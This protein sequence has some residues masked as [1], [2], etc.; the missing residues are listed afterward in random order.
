MTV[1]NVAAMATRGR[2]DAFQLGP[3]MVSPSD[4]SVL[5]RRSRPIWV[6][7]VALAWAAVPPMEATAM[8]D[9]ITLTQ[10][11]QGSTVDVTVGQSVAVD[12]PENASTGYR[13]AVDHIDPALAE[14]AEG[15]PRY[16]ASGVGAAGHAVWTFTAKAP[17]SAEIVLKRWRSWEGEAGVVERFRFTMRIKA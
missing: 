5:T 14:A 6:V 1:R 12:L 15:Q 9:P 4:L 13:W 16:P 10:A 7:A 17:G 2:L 11:A 3:V 8:P